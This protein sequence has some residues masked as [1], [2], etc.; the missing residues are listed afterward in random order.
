MRADV[1][2]GTPLERVTHTKKILHIH[3]LRADEGYLS[4]NPRIKGAGRIGRS[5]NSTSSCRCSRT[6]SWSAPSPS[7]A[8]KCGRSATSRSSWCRTSPP[9]L[10]SP[11]RNAAAQRAARI[12]PAADRNRRRPEGD[13]QFARRPGACVPGHAG[14]ATSFAKPSLASCSG[15]PTAYFERRHGRATRRRHHSAADGVSETAQA[16]VP[17]RFHPAARSQFGHPQGRAY[18][19]GD[20]RCRLRSKGRCT[21]ILTVPMLKEGQ[22]VGAITIYCQE[23]RVVLRKADELMSNFAAQAVIAIE[24]TR[25]LTGTARTDS[26]ADCDRR[27]AQGHQLVRLVSSG[28]CLRRCWRTQCASARPN[29]AICF[30]AKM[31]VSRRGART[32][33]ADLWP[34]G[35]EGVQA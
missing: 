6:M 32:R 23:A 28:R 30:Y 12:A 14:K 22:L 4:G 21:N 3:D 11:S 17:H 10:S 24:N 19:E 5:V 2:K 33:H 26:A 8:R 29:S 25:L 27:R 16:V 18:L 1:H 20:P 34:S 15:L 35:S 9:R 7:I 31:T 13:Q